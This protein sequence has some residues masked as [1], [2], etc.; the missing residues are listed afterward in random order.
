MAFDSVPVSAPEVVK[1]FLDDYQVLRA[2]S[3]L[4]NR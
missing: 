1:A 2:D 4:K 3:V